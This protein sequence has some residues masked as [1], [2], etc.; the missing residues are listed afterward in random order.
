M[1]VIFFSV[2]QLCCHLSS[3]QWIFFLNLTFIGVSLDEIVRWKKRK[4]HLFKNYVS[5]SK[6]GFWSRLALSFLDSLW[7][8]KKKKD[9][10]EISGRKCRNLRYFYYNTFGFDLLF[11]IYFII[12][13]LFECG[14]VRP[15]RTWPRLFLLG[16]EGLLR[17][18]CLCHIKRQCNGNKRCCKQTK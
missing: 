9:L 7:R 8:V 13:L 4:K 16:F 14:I 3:P 6:I 15:C 18:R 1:R 17:P 10:R 11:I 5:V 12:I 2:M